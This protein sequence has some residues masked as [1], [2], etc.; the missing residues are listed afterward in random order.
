MKKAV[1]LGSANSINNVYSDSV[2]KKLSDALD[3]ATGLVITRDGLDE[4]K[5]VL[6]EADY[7]FSTW[8]MPSLTAEEIRK[9]LPNLKAVF[10]AAGTVQKFARPFLECGIAV[11]SAWAANAVPVAEFAFAEICLASKGF[12]QR[13]HRQSCGADW[14]HRNIPVAFPG[15][16][17]IKVGIIGCGMIGRLVA[18]K[19]GTLDN[20]Q[21]LV[22]DPFLSD[23]TAESL[24][25]TKTDLKTL[26]S[27]SD[28]I[29]N[30][31]ADNPA[32][33]SMLCGELFSLMKPSAVFINT[34]RGA[35][36]IEED[37]IKSLTEVPTRAA[38][39]DV[40]M[41]EPPQDDSLL[42]TLDN[43]FLTPHI[44]GSLGNEV[45]R[46]A[47]YMYEEYKSFDEGKPTRFSVTEKMLETMA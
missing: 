45:H 35:Q 18:E 14:S 8:G 11:F 12:F 42:Y 29:S 26:F 47:E 13:L 22:Y 4:Y 41:P 10:Y 5:S 28:V 16:Y 7:V 6:D 34:G 37:L 20:I 1:F 32:T 19:L 17:D 9:Y 38:V 2:K 44:A 39:L 21:V 27:E 25:V 23:E 3:F 46:M 33:R 30:H 36:V 43:V 24:S 15:N 40:T 31:L